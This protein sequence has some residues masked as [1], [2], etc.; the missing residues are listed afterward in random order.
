MKIK[1]MVKAFYMY[2]N[3]SFLEFE[4]FRINFAL[5]GC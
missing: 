3:G 4:E 1:L 5:L 2:K